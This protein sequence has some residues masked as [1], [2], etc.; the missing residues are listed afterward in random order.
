MFELP[1]VNHPRNGGPAT[2]ELLK[3]HKWH[4]WFADNIGDTISGLE[5]LY[6]HLT[7]RLQIGRTVQENLILD[8]MDD[9][10][11]VCSNLQ[12]LL[13]LWDAPT[14]E[15]EAPQFTPE[16]P[17]GGFCAASVPQ[18]SVSNFLM[19]PWGPC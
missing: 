5:S 1:Q 6:R 16:R 12:A 19:L 3:N 15:Q 11:I 18:T 9:M 13:Q 14:G 17:F 7:Q 2:W 4:Q 10:R 8:T